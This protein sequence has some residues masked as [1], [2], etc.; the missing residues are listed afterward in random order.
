M[1]LGNICGCRSTLDGIDERIDDMIRNR[2]NQELSSEEIHQKTVELFESVSDVLERFVSLQKEIE[3]LDSQLVISIE[4]AAN[5]DELG[6]IDLPPT[7]RHGVP[8]YEKIVVFNGQI[9]DDKSTERG[10]GL[11]LNDPEIFGL[12]GEINECGIIGNIGFGDSLGANVRISFAI[13]RE[14]V[15]FIKGVSSYFYYIEW[16]DEEQAQ[17]GGSIEIRDGWY[18]FHAPGV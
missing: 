14:Y 11:F 18:Y 12:L 3:L 15:T 8:R 1:L 6:K 2:P 7:D 9:V 4:F 10:I 16:A 17:Y 13:K 5:E